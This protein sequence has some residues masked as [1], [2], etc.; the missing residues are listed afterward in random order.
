MQEERKLTN[1]QLMAISHIINSASIE[2]ASSKAKVSR[3]TLYK[4]LKDENFK[5]ELK[6]QR[7]EVIRSALDRLKG[8][9]TKAVEE[10]IKLTDAQ[11]EEVRRLACNDIITHAL[12][13]IEIEDIEQRLDKVERIVLERK[14]YK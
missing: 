1:R 9:I 4:W 10:L 11:R 6:R 12:K 7:D 14:T 5:V 8:A 13:S 2:E 3:S